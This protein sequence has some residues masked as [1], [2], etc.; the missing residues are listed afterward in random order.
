M[1]KITIANLVASHNVLASTFNDVKSLSPKTSI[2]RARIIAMIDDLR[3]RVNASTD[4]VTI[5]DLCKRHNANAKSVRARFRALYRDDATRAT[6][7][8]PVARHTYRACDVP[9]LLP[10]IVRA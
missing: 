9:A 5:V 2:P 8:V 6:M 7:P 10:Y 1:S 3:E 4:T